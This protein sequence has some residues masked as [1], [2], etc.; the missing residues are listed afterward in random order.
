MTTLT[1]LGLT[2]GAGT[3]TLVALS[4][5]GHSGGAEDLPEIASHDPEV[6]ERRVGA[7]FPTVIGERRIREGGRFSHEK[8]MAALATGHVVLVAPVGSKGDAVVDRTVEELAAPGPRLIGPHVTIAR[9]AVHGPARRGSGHGQDHFTMP[10]DPVLA[11]GMPISGAWDRFS[12]PTHK[13]IER[14]VQMLEDHQWR[15]RPTTV[16]PAAGL[17]RHAPPN[18][19]TQSVEES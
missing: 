9:S 13:A 6:L 8:V 18:P 11:H 7:P 15:S 2:G 14:W 17:A 19:W 1:F 3:T 12:R 4:L 16:S 5:L 10:Y